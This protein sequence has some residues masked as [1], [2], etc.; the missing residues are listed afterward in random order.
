MLTAFAV[1][2]TSGLMAQSDSLKSGVF[3]WNNLK[4]QNVE[5]RERK[6]VLTGRSLD[7]AE[8]EVHITTLE[9]GQSP[10]GA[11]VHNDFE[12]LIIVKEGKLKVTI[13]DSNKILG[14]GG[15]ALA[16]KGDKHSFQ[17]ASEEPVSY[18]VLKFKPKSIIN[19]NQESEAGGSF[20]KDWSELV[21]KKTDKGESRGIF[22]RPTTLFKRFEMHATALN[23]GIASHAPH[24]HRAEEI[25]LMIK[26][27]VTQQIGQAFY[28][29]TAG[30]LIF[31]AS[32]DLHASKNTGSELCGYFAIQWNN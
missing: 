4:T 7:L 21:M 18:Y 6:Q 30:D 5:G 25:I 8:L 17:N 12:E 19:V 9:K 27:N 15:I 1:I 11:H 32:G 13:K 10:H 26:G 2:I 3:A 22:N 24:T 16:L 23:P 20:A 29:V 14:P 31:L 28:K